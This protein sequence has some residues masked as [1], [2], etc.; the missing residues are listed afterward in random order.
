MLRWGQQYA[1]KKIWC[2]K[3]NSWESAKSICHSLPLPFVEPFCKRNDKGI[4]NFFECNGHKW[5]NNYPYQ[6]CPKEREQ[7]LEQGKELPLSIENESERNQTNRISKLSTT[8]W[9]VRAKCFQRILENC[10]Y[11]YELWS[12]CLEEPNLTR[13]E[14]ARIIG[15]KAQM[16][17]FDL[18]FGG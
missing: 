2:S 11:L 18:Y 15:C 6:I 1:W 10:S 14:K 5:W 12:K 13:D 16:E 17:G 7:I 3:K 4:E 9:T 8:R